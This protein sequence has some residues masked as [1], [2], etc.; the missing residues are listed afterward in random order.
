MR[1]TLSIAGKR[2]ELD[3]ADGAPIVDVPGV[4]CP[5]CGNCAALRVGGRVVALARDGHL[6]AAL[7]DHP[8]AAVET[9]APDLQVQITDVEEYSHGWTGN[10]ECVRCRRIVGE[11]HVHLDTIFGRE[12]DRRMLRDSARWRVY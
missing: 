6:E 9:G 7:A 4:L 1:V 2:H 12:E 3:V 11:M 10:A 5:T 8:G